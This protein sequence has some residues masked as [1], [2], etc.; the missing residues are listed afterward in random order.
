MG[1]VIHISQT[2]YSLQEELPLS[3]IIGSPVISK[4]G[5][6]LGK[7]KEVYTREVVM[8]G[9]IVKCFFGPRSFIGREYFGS[10]QQDALLLSIDPVTSM[11][12]LPVLDVNGKMLGKV[13][14]VVRD[15]TRNR[16]ERIQVKKHIFKRPIEFSPDDIDTV[17]QHIILKVEVE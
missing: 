4:S 17:S 2:P 3:S 9:V 12:G 1:K 7:V 5:Q 6:E 13:V 14:R 15:D 11:V 8:L 16:F 10:I